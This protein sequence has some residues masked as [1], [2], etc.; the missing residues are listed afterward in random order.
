MLTDVTKLREFYFSPLGIASANSITNALTALWGECKGERVMGI[1]YTPPWLDRFGSD[2]ERVLNFMPAAQGAV[3]WP[4]GKLS[5]T[6]LALEEELPLADSSIDRI[7]MVH[8]LEHSENPTETL[9]EIWRV[10][11]PN[12][13]LFIVVPN[14]RGLWARFEHTPFGTG[15]PFS[16]RQLSDFLQSAL[17]TPVS[18]SDALHFPPGKINRQPRFREKLETISRRF[19]PVFSGV[20]V[21]EATKNLY[22]GVPAISRQSRRIFVPVLVPQGSSTASRNRKIKKTI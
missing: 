20:I 3:H 10:L 21:V 22:Q 19:W 18:W 4:Y 9:R 13:K 14:R 12:G 11:A 17:L 5:A 2:C 1:G 8:L 16:K 15:R 6:A 7:V